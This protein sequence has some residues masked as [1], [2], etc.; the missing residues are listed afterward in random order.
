MSDELLP[1]YEKEL[2]YIRQL[3]AEFSKEHPKI[4]SRL[5]VNNDSI[6]DPHVSR[7]IE[8][9]AFLNARIQHKLDD[10]FPEISDALLGTLYPHYQR[11]IPSMSIVQF[12]ADK[13]QLD[14][15][16]TIASGTL[17]ETTQFQ[18]EN[19]RFTTSY[20]VPLL[21]I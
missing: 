15:N 13:E 11:P 5:G 17:L 6:E 4:A 1:F 10:D 7:L 3:G 18:G 9:F 21:P 19:C 12:E 16:Y 20:E 2:V 14:S 8:S